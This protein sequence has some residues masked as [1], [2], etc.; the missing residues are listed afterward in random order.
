MNP[1]IS[2]KNVLFYAVVLI[3]CGSGVAFT[4]WQGADLSVRETP[5]KKT[6]IVDQP[7][8]REPLSILLAQVVVIIITAK[9]VG[10]LFQRIGQP[11]VIGE[12]AAGIL[13]GPSVLGSTWPTAF[14]W[15]FP[16]ASLG[17]LSLL[18]QVGVILFMFVVGID[19]DAQHLR[20]MAQ[21]VVLVSHVSIVVPFFLGTLLSLFIF[22]SFAAA[23]IPF[24]G[25]ALFM[26]VSLSI[27]AF[28]VLARIIEERGLTKTELGN[29]AIACAAVDDVTAWCLLAVVVAIVKAQGA[30]GVMLTIGLSLAFVVFMLL[31]M[32][33]ILGR[34]LAGRAKDGVLRRGMAAS[35]LV[36]VF[37]SALATEA[38]GIHALFGA[39]LAGVAMPPDAELRQALKKGLESFSSVFLLPIFF[40]ITGLRTDVGLLDDWHSWLTCATVI[41]VAILGKLVGSALAA[42]WTGMSWHDSMALGVLLNTRGLVELIVLNTGYDLGILPRPIFAIMVLMALTTTFMTG[43]LIWLLSERR[44]A[45]PQPRSPEA[46]GSATVEK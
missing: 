29:T 25:F 31:V 7:E 43:P 32:K 42:R 17:P 45:A 13:L 1:L 38:I 6:S 20:K 30:G 41:V 11:A 22:E 23:H 40:A 9:L 37:A 8:R 4:L 35:I 28:P 15:L 21:T 19:L 24:S 3:V 44:L 12:M 33:P 14:A 18:S 10:G 46:S 34:L 16:E 2:W 27:T 36:L 26:G 39:F 5:A